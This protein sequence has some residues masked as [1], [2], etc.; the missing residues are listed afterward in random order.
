MWETLLRD[1]FFHASL[2]ATTGI[3][4]LLRPNRW[5]RT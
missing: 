3:D 5:M 1:K 4:C 2:V